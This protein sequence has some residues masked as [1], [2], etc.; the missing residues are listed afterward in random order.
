MVVCL[1]VRMEQQWA[2]VMDD[3]MDKWMVGCSAVRSE[4]YWVA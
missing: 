4:L 2:V 3:L 1:V